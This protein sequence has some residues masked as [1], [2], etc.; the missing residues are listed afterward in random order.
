LQFTTGQC[1][2]P[3]VCGDTKLASIANV[4][5]YDTYKFIG[6]AGEA[7]VFSALGASGNVCAIAQLYS[8]TGVF[9]G[10]ENCNTSTGSIVLPSDGTYTLMVFDSSLR[11]TGSYALTLQFTTGQCASPIVCGETKSASIANISEYDTYKF[12]GKAGEAI[13]FSALGTSGDVCAI[14]Q[15]Y[16]PTGV[17]LGQENCNTSTGSIVLPSDGTYTLLVFDSSL[18]RMGTYAMTLQF[19]TGQCASSIVCGDPK[20]ANI[21]NVSEYDTYKFNGKAGEAVV[22]SALGT[23]GDVCA[24]AQLY[25]PT[26]VF[27]AQE[28]C[29]TSTGSIVLPSD[30]SYTLLVFDSSLRRTGSYA[31]TLQFTTGQCAS[32]IVCGETKSAN[33]ANVS[34]YDTYKFSGRAGGTVVLTGL[35]TSGGVCAIAQLYSPTGVFLG[36]ENCNTSSGSIPLP[37]EGSYTILVFDSSLRRTG[38]YNLSLSCIGFQVRTRSR[39]APRQTEFKLNPRERRGNLPPPQ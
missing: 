13:V 26:G 4:S 39:A 25:S 28:N 33:I 3:I 37:S 22:F 16:S 32:P 18:R 7:I 35:G 12:N 10:Q 24:I 15:L 19:T 11:R 36:Q 30:G 14:A 9:L 1:A 29:N 20:L 21:A 31:M 38:S 17:F 5:E 8:P 27:L 34:E 23:S 6:R 2:S